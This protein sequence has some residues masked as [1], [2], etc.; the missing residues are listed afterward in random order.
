MSHAARL[1]GLRALLATK[2]TTFVVSFVVS[3][4]GSFVLAIGARIGTI[5]ILEPG[6]LVVLAAVVGA[7]APLLAFHETLR[8]QGN[9]RANREVLLTQPLGAW[10]LPA[11]VHLGSLAWCL[12][13]ILG[14]LP[15]VAV[16]GLPV[17]LS[18]LGVALAVG[19][20]L[21]VVASYSVAVGNNSAQGVLLALLVPGLW[22]LVP[23]GAGYGPP[24]TLAL[25]LWLGALGVVVVGALLVLPYLYYA[26]PV[27]L[28]QEGALKQKPGLSWPEGAIWLAGGG[29]ILSGFLSLAAALALFVPAALCALQARRAPGSRPRYRSHFSRGL[30]LLTL[31][32]LP[33]FGAGL[34][35]DAQHFAAGGRYDP[36]LHVHFEEAPQGGR[37]AVLLTE[38]IEDERRFGEPGCRSAAKGLGRVAIVDAAG[39]V[40]A[41]LPPRFGAMGDHAW[42]SDGRYLAVHDLGIGRTEASLPQRVNFVRRSDAGERWGRMFEQAALGTVIFDT[43]SGAVT[44][45]PLAEIRPGWTTPDELVHHAL[46]WSG[47]HVLSDGRGLAFESQAEEVEVLR[48]TPEGPIVRLSDYTPEGVLLPGAAA[49]YRLGAAGL[50]PAR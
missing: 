17:S 23:L 40:E 12:I 5:P 33:C 24:Q 41:L 47:Q 48:Y 16:F 34:I 21:W 20:G 2:R 25:G 36:S 35:Y 15:A 8:V 30:R 42:S 10:A 45:I 4:V 31:G 7:V 28:W 14:A 46:G 6:V 19:A 38:R 9:G 37:R 27:C 49:E 22:M 43:R 39:Q 26:Q 29:L 3:L 13:V 44:R 50:E 1:R 32:L 18:K 11:Y